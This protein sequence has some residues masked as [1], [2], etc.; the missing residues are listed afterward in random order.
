MKEGEKQTDGNNA[1][2]GW[3]A[4]FLGLLTVSLLTHSHKRSGY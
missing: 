3:C 2:E 4:G 1:R